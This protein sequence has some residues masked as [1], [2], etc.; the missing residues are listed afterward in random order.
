MEGLQNYNSA[1]SGFAAGAGQ[2][3]QNL[4]NF[5]A[6]K[7]AVKS[8]NR[9]LVAAA[10]EKLDLDTLK[11]VGQEFGV[12][13][14][15]QLIGKYGSKIMAKTGLG[16]LDESIGNKIRSGIKSAGQR[17]KS[18]IGQ[19]GEET[20]GTE[21]SSSAGGEGADVEMTDMTGTARPSAPAEE[22]PDNPDFQSSEPIEP[23]EVSIDGP[24]TYNSRALPGEGESEEADNVLGRSGSSRPSNELGNESEFN[25]EGSGVADDIGTDAAPEIEDAATQGVGDAV[26]SAIG[27]GLEGLGAALDATGIGAPIGAL[28]GVAGA[29]LEGGALYEAGKSV[30]DW[31]EQDILGEKPKVNKQAIPTAPTTLAQAGLMATPIEDTSM[32]LPSTSSAF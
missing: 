27:D 4:G 29:V 21:P 2:I 11:S 31:F 12:R 6:H 32:D 22:T 1:M 8:Y 26:K 14:G 16:D 28:A 23:D 18:S 9:G 25:A 19:E 15:K 24:S 10:D 7:D 20:D 5:R 30:V 13:M 17:L 3:N